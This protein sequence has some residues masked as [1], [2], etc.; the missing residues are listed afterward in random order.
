MSGKEKIEKNQFFR[1]ANGDYGLRG[2]DLKIRKERSRLDIRKY[3][4]GQRVV[5]SWN[6]LPQKVVD[7]QSI[8][9]FKN[10]L[11]RH[12]QDMDATGSIA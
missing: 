1:P 7:A 10:L 12:W 9:Q 11:D 5:N 2:H 6:R 8:N 3:S 4:F